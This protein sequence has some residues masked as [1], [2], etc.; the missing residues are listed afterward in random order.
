VTATITL[1]TLI[2]HAM[3]DPMIPAVPYRTVDWDALPTVTRQITAH[4]GHVGFHGCGS[5]LPWYV[6]RVTK[7]LATR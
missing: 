7:F 1:P 4:G 5:R 3:D 6:G 2:I